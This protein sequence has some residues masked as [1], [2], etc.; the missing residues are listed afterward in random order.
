MKEPI[1][2]A[3]KASTYDVV[4]SALPVAPVSATLYE[5]SAKIAQVDCYSQENQLLFAADKLS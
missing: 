2:E 5:S 3:F 1:V 4:L